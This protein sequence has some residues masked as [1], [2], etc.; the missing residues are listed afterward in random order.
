MFAN[1]FNFSYFDQKKHKFANIELDALLSQNIKLTNIVSEHPLEN[2]EILNDAIHN[3]PLEMSFSAVVSDMPQITIKNF[4]DPSI[5]ID[6]VLGNLGLKTLK[7]SKSLKAWKELFLV[8]KSKELVTISSPIQHEVFENMAILNI[9]AELEPIQG[10]VFCANLKQVLISENIKK[11][12]LSPEIGK[13][14]E[15]P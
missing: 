5:V 2:G 14:S 11:M 7:S 6:S 8:W 10:I 13:Q 3:Q 1:G 15:R 4:T 12:S 9:T